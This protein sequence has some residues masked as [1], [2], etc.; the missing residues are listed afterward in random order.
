MLINSPKI[1][2]VRDCHLIYI[3]E[4]LFAIDLECRGWPVAGL[5]SNRSIFL[6]PDAKDIT[7]PLPVVLHDTQPDNWEI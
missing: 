3:A 6:N 2:A 5:V 4:K 1:S 7:L